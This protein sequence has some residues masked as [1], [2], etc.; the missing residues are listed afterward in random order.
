MKTETII[1]VDNDS[2]S[3]WEQTIITNDDGTI[4]V[5]TD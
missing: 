2:N 4:T 3:E 1:T 5:I